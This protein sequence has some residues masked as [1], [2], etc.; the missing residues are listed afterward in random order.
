MSP[1]VIAL[2]PGEFMRIEAPR[3]VE[4]SVR[5]GRLWITEEARNDDIWLK[6]GESA[7]LAGDGLALIEALDASCVRIEH[8]RRKLELGKPRERT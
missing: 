4:V 1:T 6:A 7:S 5:S 8:D 3:G 2:S